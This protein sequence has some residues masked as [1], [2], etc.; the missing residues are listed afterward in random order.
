MP[1]NTLAPTSRPVLALNDGPDLEFLRAVD[2]ADIPADR[3][4]A[5]WTGPDPRR[6]TLQS[7]ERRYPVEVSRR[8]YTWGT[9]GWECIVR[10]NPRKSAIIVTLH[11]NVVEHATVKSRA[12][13]LKIADRPF[14]FALGSVTMCLGDIADH[15]T[16]IHPALWTSIELHDLVEPRWFYQALTGFH[17]DFV[18]ALIMQGSTAGALQ[19]LALDP[20][21][22]LAR[23]VIADFPGIKQAA[24]GRPI[25]HLLWSNTPRAE[26]ATPEET[27]RLLGGAYA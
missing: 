8:Q 13:A 22:E 24:N 19:F 9:S 27:E 12:K 15:L 1:S 25:A 3:S 20:T 16:V 4:F 11:G 21:H 18:N 6:P 17:V 5:G 14:E 23:H 10:S 26:Q 2:L 7:L